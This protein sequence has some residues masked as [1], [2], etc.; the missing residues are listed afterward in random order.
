MEVEDYKLPSIWRSQLKP[1]GML[2]RAR[3]GGKYTALQEAKSLPPFVADVKRPPDSGD[4]GNVRKVPQTY[5]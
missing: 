5:S 4:F 1:V 2:A 3:N